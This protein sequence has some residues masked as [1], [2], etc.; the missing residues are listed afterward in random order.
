MP[1][2]RST[3]AYVPYYRLKREE[4]ARAW[5][6]AAQRGEKAVANFDED[7]VTMAVEAG[8]EC[9]KGMDRQLVDGLYFATTTAPYKEKQ[10]AAI[11][12]AALD[13]PK[14]VSTADF[15][16]SLRAGTGAL[17]AALDAV[18]AGSAQ[19]VLVVAADCR[20]GAP[21]SELE[22]VFGDGAA[23]V[24][25]GAG[26]GVDFTDS[27]THASEIID[28]WRTDGQPF[29][30]MWEDRFVYTQGYLA[31]IK[32]AAGAFLKQQDLTIQDFNRVVLYAP[33]ARRHQEACRT[34]KLNKEQAQ[35]R[36]FDLVGNTGAALA[37]LMLVEAVEAAEVN[38][39]LLLLNYGDGCDLLA[40]QV[41]AK[42]PLS[43]G[44]KGVQEYLEAKRY[45]AN[46]EKLIR[47]RRLMEVAAGRRR[48]PL[49]S[50]TVAIHRDRKMI[51]SLH[52]SECTNCGRS[53]F[54]PQRVCLYCQAKDQYREI[55]LAERK[56]TLF[57]FCKDELAQSVDPPVVISIVNL[58]GNLRFYGQMTDRDP[59][60][61]KLDLPV[62]LTFRR[63]SEAEGFVNYFWKCR[64]V[65]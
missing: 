23:A 52:G 15:T 7:S 42:L 24:L 38:D 9:L 36:L 6:G 57:T 26:G 62:E 17:K 18:K 1:A 43:A 32:E 63:M 61:I 55:S 34:L 40:F 13:L 45:L 35:N 47:M 58:E 60:E 53:F 39:R 16:N 14:N 8:R 54:P 22:Q 11:I 3:G 59:D 25:V 49:V 4:I 19:N 30:K 44:R 27:Y 12:A 64:P 10:C 21:G 28:Q 2:I 50:S 65:R 33:D 31:H 29:V 37:L 46:Y 41:K 48:P 56:G 51:Y 5:G 20:L